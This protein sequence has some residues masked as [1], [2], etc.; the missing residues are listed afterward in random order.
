[1][2]GPP[3]EQTSGS[4]L[5]CEHYITAFV[6]LRNSFLQTLIQNI[7]CLDYALYYIPPWHAASDAPPPVART[8]AHCQHVAPALQYPR[9]PSARPATHLLKYKKRRGSVRPHWNV[10]NDDLCHHHR[11]H[12]KHHHYSHSDHRHSLLHHYLLYHRRHH[13]YLLHHYLI[14]HRRH[15]HTWF[16]GRYL[17]KGFVLLPRL[18]GLP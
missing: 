18:R 5:Y 9:V 3:G 13:H 6:H 15:Y 4:L 7:Y 11:R 17:A 2:R 16:L 12:P 14:H 1:M 8:S 10:G